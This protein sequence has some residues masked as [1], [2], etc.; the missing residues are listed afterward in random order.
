MKSSKSSG[1]NLVKDSGSF[2]LIETMISYIEG[3]FVYMTQVE[4]TDIISHDEE[5][6]CPAGTKKTLLFESLV[7]NINP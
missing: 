4:E 3:A 7:I 6:S 1:Y 2:D 5:G